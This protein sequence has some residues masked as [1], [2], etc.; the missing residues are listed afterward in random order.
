M[1]IYIYNVY[2]YI[3]IYKY[4]RPAEVRP[5]QAREPGATRVPGP[6]MSPDLSVFG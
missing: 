1:Y 2:I 6:G 3:Y 5:W 4:G